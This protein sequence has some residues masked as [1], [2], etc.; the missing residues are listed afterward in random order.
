MANDNS[1]KLNTYLPLTAYLPYTQVY[2]ATAKLVGNPDEV[3]V[4]FKAWCKQIP[5]KNQSQKNL[6]TM[7]LLT[8]KMNKKIDFIAVAPQLNELEMTNTGM[9]RPVWYQN[10]PE[11]VRIKLEWN[12][13]FRC[14]SFHSI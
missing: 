6:G 7:V 13:Q 2:K 3:L 10:E 11:R 8:N 1:C 12:I 5:F 9:D 14:I 4:T